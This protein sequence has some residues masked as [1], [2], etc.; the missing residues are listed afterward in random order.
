MGEARIREFVPLA[1]VQL[2]LTDQP[3]GMARLVFC[4]KLQPVTFCQYTVTVL[5][6]WLKYS[7]GAPGVWT[8]EIRPR[9]RR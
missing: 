2:L 7:V 4:C 1:V 8:T 9:N 6:E 3:A 5:P